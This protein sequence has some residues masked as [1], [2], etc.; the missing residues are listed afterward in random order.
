MLKYQEQ[1][2]IKIQFLCFDADT[3][4]N[5]TKPTESM[6]V[7]SSFQHPIKNPYYLFFSWM[8]IIERANVDGEADGK[9]F[10]SL[11]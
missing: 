8:I 10:F 9:L 2:I 6:F 1:F 11:I 7:L 5:A 4:N 3:E